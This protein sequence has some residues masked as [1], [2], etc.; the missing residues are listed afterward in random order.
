MESD[1]CVAAYAVA[2][3]VLRHI[4]SVYPALWAQVPRAARVSVRNSIVAAVRVELGDR[5]ARTEAADVTM[6][7]KRVEDLEQQLGREVD[8]NV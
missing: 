5:L 2:D 7:Q 3:R 4:D 6:L 1:L 8:Q